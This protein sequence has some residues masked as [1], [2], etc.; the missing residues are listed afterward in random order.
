VSR[1]KS[2]GD[3]SDEFNTLSGRAG[4]GDMVF[5]STAAKQAV[6]A[7][8]AYIAKMNSL[9]HTIA[10]LQSLDGFGGFSTSIEAKEF[11]DIQCRNW[12]QQAKD[13]AV[14]AK[15]MADAFEAAAGCIITQEQINQSHVAGSGP[16]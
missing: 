13:C 14:V 11:Y 4:N 5:E 2:L 8:N 9:S 10:R 7:C 3:L 6:A 1:Y 15:A 16:H 12:A